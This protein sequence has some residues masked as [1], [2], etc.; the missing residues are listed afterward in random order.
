MAENKLQKWV[1]KGIKKLGIKGTVVYTG[2][3][4]HKP[5]LWRSVWCF[6]NKL[7][8]SQIFYPK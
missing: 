7:N 1:N 5:A 2:Q 4:V 3:N 6:L 8:L